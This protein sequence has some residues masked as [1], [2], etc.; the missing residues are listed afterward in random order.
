MT[1]PREIMR[2]RL[3][4]VNLGGIAP[5]GSLFGTSWSEVNRLQ[6]ELDRWQLE[7]RGIIQPFLATVE[8]QEVEYGDGMEGTTIEELVDRARRVGGD[9]WR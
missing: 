5:G 9:E 4:E 1:D 2:R 3:Q 8:G 7:Q 6:S